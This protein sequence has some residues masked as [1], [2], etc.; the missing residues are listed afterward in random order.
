[1]VKGKFLLLGTGA[2]TGIPVIG[3]RCAVCTSG[4]ERL[5]PSAL[6][7]ISGKRLVIDVGP[8]FRL[9]AL[10]YG[11]TALDGVLLTHSHFDH[12]A[13]LDELRVYH[14]NGGVKRMPLLLSQETFEAIRQRCY[15][16]MEEQKDGSI[17]STRFQFHT[18]NRPVGSV[19]F[20]T[21]HLEFFTV[22]QKEM[23]VLGFRFGNLAYISDIHDYEERI[24]ES[25]SG[26]KTL[27]ID[28][29]KEEKS[30]G[31]LSLS[32]AIGFAQKCG[33]ERVY[34]TH[35]AH[36]MNPMTVSRKLPS[37]MQLAYDGLELE[38]EL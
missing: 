38:F 20:E 8:D 33:A 1:M 2:S 10:K 23:K 24:F 15:Y 12:V 21:V 27:I 9:Q 29:L 6:V 35:I 16:F 36:E 26:V 31:H 18:L 7:D 28:A 32:E 14:F 3:C 5:R 19:T 34:F 13:G 17:L 25:L 22:S 37:H 11:I 4:K 30:I